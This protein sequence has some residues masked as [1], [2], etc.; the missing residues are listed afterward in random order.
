MRPH[1]VPVVM[2]VVFGTV[3]FLTSCGVVLTA[4]Y[5]A[6]WMGLVALSAAV[7]GALWVAREWHLFAS[8]RR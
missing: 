4:F 2:A 6:G 7:G 3:L 8:S 1:P 5:V